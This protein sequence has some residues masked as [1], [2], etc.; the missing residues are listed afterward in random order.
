MLGKDNPRGTKKAE[1]LM[2]NTETKTNFIALLLPTAK[3]VPE[4]WRVLLQ[5]EVPDVPAQS[6]L[7]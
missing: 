2:G 3:F 1:R 7:K 4:M 5:D 6:Q